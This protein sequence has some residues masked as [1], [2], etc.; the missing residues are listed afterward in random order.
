MSS[1][2]EIRFQ[3][4]QLR[5]TA[6]ARSSTRGGE[7]GLVEVDHPAH[8]VAGEEE[9]VRLPVTV[10]RPL[11]QRPQMRPQPRERLGVGVLDRP[12]PVAAGEVVGHGRAQR[13]QPLD[14][15]HGLPLDGAELDD[16]PG[17]ALRRGSGKSAAR[18]V[19]PREH[20]PGRDDVGVAGK[21]VPAVRSGVGVLARGRLVQLV[22]EAGRLDQADGPRGRH[23]AVGQVVREQVLAPELVDVASHRRLALDVHVVARGRAAAGDR[24]E[25]APVPGTATTVP[26]PTTAAASASVIGSQ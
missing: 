10:Q 16:E 24:E 22:P 1:P 25:P 9:V 6:T 3:K 5:S 2:A 18:G 13:G 17:L 23:A 14:G 4:K 11:G 21:R 20:P 26:A 12:V 8:L 19:Q 15:G 7:V